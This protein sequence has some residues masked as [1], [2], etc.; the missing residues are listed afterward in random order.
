M[1]ADKSRHCFNYNSATMLLTD[2][3][4][5]GVM[6]APSPITNC[7]HPHWCIYY[8]IVII[9]KVIVQVIHMP[10]IYQNNNNN[11]NSKNKM[12]AG[13]L[14]MLPPID[15]L[16]ARTAAFL[17]GFVHLHGHPSAVAVRVHHPRELTLVQ[18]SLHSQHDVV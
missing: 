7:L 10:M 18:A 17:S 3:Q 11:N 13:W 2:A 8:I 15:R 14:P 5:T 16:L 1:L 9:I 12:A 6:N 4:T